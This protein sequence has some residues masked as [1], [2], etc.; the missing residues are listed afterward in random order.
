MRGFDVRIGGFD[1]RTVGYPHGESIPQ[2]YPHGESIL[3]GYPHGLVSN[4]GYP[5][6]LVNNM[7]YP[8]VPVHFWD[9]LTFL[10]TSGISSRS[11]SLNSPW[12]NVPGSRITL[13]H[14]SRITHW[15][16]F[17]ALPAFLALPECTPACAL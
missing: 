9:I 10:Y 17:L 4:M 1:V 5:H 16:M 14:A 7:G 3:Q 11:Y 12:S 13:V 8:H 15:D 6:G 2:G